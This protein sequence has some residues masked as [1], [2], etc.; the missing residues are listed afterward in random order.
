MTE[1]RMT[2]KVARALIGCEVSDEPAPYPG[3]L[4]TRQLSLSHPTI[5]VALFWRAPVSL[6]V[7]RILLPWGV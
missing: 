3:P 5:R 2:N 6:G 4:V 1:T 7:A